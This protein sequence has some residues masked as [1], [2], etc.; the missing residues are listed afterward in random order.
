MDNVPA[1]LVEAG[2]LLASS[3]I[4]LQQNIDK[5]VAGESYVSVTLL[6]RIVL[7]DTFAWHQLAM[8]TYIEVYTHKRRILG[9]LKNIHKTVMVQKRLEQ[10]AMRDSLTRLYNRASGIALV[11]KNLA[12]QSGKHA[13]F[14]FD[15]DDFKVTNDSYGH[16][17]GDM[18]LRMLAD[19]LRK[20]FRPADVVFRVGGDEFSAFVSP[21]RKVQD[22][23]KICQRILK[24]IGEAKKQGIGLNVS[25]GVCLGDSALPYEEYYRKADE[26]LYFIK[27]QKQGVLDAKYAIV[28]G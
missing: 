9:F 26:A 11:K 13:F 14:M 1:S 15:V 23:D 5:L 7:T 4:L 18:A 2:Y 24:N 20:S 19:V 22:A 10:E 3:G 21:V 27:R 16:E 28:Q 6:A 8:T 12:T 25:I 17:Y